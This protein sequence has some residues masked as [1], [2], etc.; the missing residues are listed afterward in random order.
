MAGLKISSRYITLYLHEEL[1][2][3]IVLLCFFKAAIV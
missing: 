1:M 2:G 3:N